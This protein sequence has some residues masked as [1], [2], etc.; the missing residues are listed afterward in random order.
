MNDND[1]NSLWDEL[2]I[3]K[4]EVCVKNKKAIDYY[5]FKSN[6]LGQNDWSKSSK[7]FLTGILVKF[8][9]NAVAWDGPNQ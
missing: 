8:G 6:T 2:N 4:R 9:G 1:K 7:Y 3:R 5:R